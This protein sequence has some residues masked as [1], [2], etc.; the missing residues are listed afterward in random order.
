MCYWG[1]M[2]KEKPSYFE[3]LLYD[4]KDV[5]R[6]FYPL[7]SYLSICIMSLLLLYTVLFH[8][9]KWGYIVFLVIVVAFMGRR[10][11]RVHKYGGAKNLKGLS[12]NDLV[13]G[14]KR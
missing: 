1:N 12:I 4:K 3:W 7:A 2:V 13:W 5:V 11:Y 6:I 10:M 14:G 8:R 9:E